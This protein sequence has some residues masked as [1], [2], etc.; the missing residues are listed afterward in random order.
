[1]VSASGVIRITGSWNFSYEDIIGVP[2]TTSSYVVPSVYA[3]CLPLRIMSST[4]SYSAPC[5]PLKRSLIVLLFP[6]PVTA[7]PH[8][9]CCLSF[10]KIPRIHCRFNW[11]VSSACVIIVRCGT[12]MKPEVWVNQ[13]RYEVVSRHVLIFIGSKNNIN[14]YRTAINLERYKEGWGREG[15]MGREEEMG[16]FL[17]KRE[18]MR[19]GGAFRREQKEEGGA[20]G[21]EKRLKREIPST[22][23]K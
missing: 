5:F 22:K 2:S 8:G 13:S 19:K 7:S 3:I 14:N 6:F 1:M 4:D 20:F 16:R 21:K 17:Q 9:V 11:S 12:W 23:E 15:V 10:L 18:E